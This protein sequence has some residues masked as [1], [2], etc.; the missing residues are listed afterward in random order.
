MN[1]SRIICLI[2]FLV[3]V[4]GSVYIVTSFSRSFTGMDIIPA[5]YRAEYEKQKSMS[6]KKISDDSGS[7]GFNW[8]DRITINEICLEFEGVRYVGEFSSNPIKI[9]LFKNIRNGTN[10]FLALNQTY[11]IIDSPLVTIT[12]T[13]IYDGLYHP[14]IHYKN[15]DITAAY[16]TDEVYLIIR[17]L[18]S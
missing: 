5:E 8:R 4:F 18:N 9:A 2:G 10:I 17:G 16:D 7:I 11:T 1:Y 3:V 14:E 15:G 6:F 12:I 13:N